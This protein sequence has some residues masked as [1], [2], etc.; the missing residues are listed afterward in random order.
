DS[1]DTITAT[2]TLATPLRG[3]ISGA[4]GTFNPVTGAWVAT[5]TVSQ[6]NTALA[7]VAFVPNPKNDQ[8]TSVTALI[9]D[10]ANTGPAAGTITLDVTPVNEPPS[11]ITLTGTSVSEN[12]A[13]GTPIGTLAAPDPDTGDTVTLT[14]QDSAGGR[15]GISGASLVVADGSQINFE[16]AKSH[17]V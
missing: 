1:A 17:Q 14:L 12:A 16:V 2:L 4:G 5:G 11:D 8:D 3:I 7:S 6:V 9:R 10:A 15:F 13:N